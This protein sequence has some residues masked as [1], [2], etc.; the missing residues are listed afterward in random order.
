MKSKCHGRLRRLDA[1]IMGFDAVDAKNRSGYDR[2]VGGLSW[3]L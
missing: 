2:K 1:K 3:S